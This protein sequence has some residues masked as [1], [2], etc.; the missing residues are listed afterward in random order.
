MFSLRI[1]PCVL[2]Q[3]RQA[4]PKPPACA[5]KALEKY[6][7]LLESL[8]FKA[9]QRGRDPYDLKVG[10]YSIPVSILTHQGPQLNAGKWRL[11]AWLKANQLDLVKVVELGSNLNGLV[12]RV[13]LTD[14]VTI[15]DARSDLATQ[16]AAATS[17]A[18]IDA[19]LSGSDIANG[20][21][22][23]RLYPDYFT[24]LS[25]QARDTL[26]DLA[27]ID[28]GSLQAYITWLNTKATKL[29][30]TR[31]E[32]LTK[33]AMVIH[34]VA[35]YTRGF[36]PMRRKPSAFGRMYYQGLSVQNV[37]KTLRRA[38]L[39][40]C[41]EYD[42]RASVIT[43]KL[44]FA[45]ELAS[46][47]APNKPWTSV[48][49]ASVLYVENRAEF[50]RDVRAA[51]F[52]TNPVTTREFQDSLIKQAITAIGF[53]ARAQSQGW[54]E[55]DGSWSTVALGNILTSS[56]DREH[57]LDCPI[58]EK[59]IDEQTQLDKY[60]EA[61]V[62]EQLPDVYFGELVTA[63][64]RPSRSKAVAYIYQHQETQAMNTAR[65]VL[66]QHG[67]KPIANIHDAFIVRHKL[68]VSVQ[69][70]VIDAI[71]VDMGNELY[72]IK[73]NRLEGFYK[74]YQGE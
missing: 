15:N 35:K 24:A 45:R 37:D 60:L 7:R 57:F 68:P 52:G 27:P 23:H 20:E 71:R 28:I 34:A 14:L 55:Q 47:I 70:A 67:I 6:R 33:Q 22:F 59:F 11:H 44:T 72:T 39:G 10:T 56:D 43:W 42:I 41:W 30:P 36:L 2:T 18:E 17:A 61:G 51:T 62:K 9:I 1:D 12:S 50:M 74:S 19:L 63:K 16:L 49:W 29:N 8:V 48:F 69:H 64:V 54:R 31:I 32:Q 5:E 66:A 21:L 13:K 40:D 46:Q 53:G 65:A 58:I 73:A 3:L 26:Y 25:S 4:F 38:M